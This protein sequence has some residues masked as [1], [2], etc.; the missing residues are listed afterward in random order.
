MDNGVGM[1]GYD[2]GPD[3]NRAEGVQHVGVEPWGRCVAAVR[4]PALLDELGDCI[5]L[6][7]VPAVSA[8]R[9]VG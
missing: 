9:V 7:H 4:V 8:S 1:R 3:L 2:D 6:H 5:K